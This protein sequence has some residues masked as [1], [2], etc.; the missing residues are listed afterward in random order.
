MLTTIQKV[1]NR[2]RRVAV[3]IPDRARFDDEEIMLL[4][5]SF[6]L[7]LGTF[8]VVGGYAQSESDHDLPVVS[9]LHK[10]ASGAVGGESVG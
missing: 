7:I 4:R 10:D 3:P 6:V 1:L 8:F 5:L 9:P 2:L